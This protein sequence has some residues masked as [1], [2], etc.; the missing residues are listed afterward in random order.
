MTNLLILLFIL[1]V[2]LVSWIIYKVYMR[3]V[4]F[5]HVIVIFLIQFNPFLK[6]SKPA[7]LKMA[8]GVVSDYRSKYYDSILDDLYN[9]LDTIIAKFESN[10]YTVDSVKDFIYS[11]LIPVTK[12]IMN[13]HD[14]KKTI[15][16]R[17]DTILLQYE[18]T[19][20]K[21]SLELSDKLI[22]L[23]DTHKLEH[24]FSLIGLEKSL[25]KK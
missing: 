9:K 7:L 16:S 24:K 18:D 8:S 2:T 21:L 5:Y 3:E 15:I 20:S 13:Y 19:I 25:L 6:N 11:F 1:A 4:D 14:Y 23:D 17:N 10:S 22:A 12:I